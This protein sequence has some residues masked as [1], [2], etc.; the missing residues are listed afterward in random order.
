MEHT[1]KLETCKSCDGS[2]NYHRISCP[3]L[4]IHGTKRLRAINAALLSALEAL[5]K[6]TNGEH[7]CV[8]CTSAPSHCPWCQ[9]RAA[10]KQAKEDK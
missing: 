10:I 8:D 2:K 1:P 9:A 4:D 6:Y 5:Y 3:E 7:R